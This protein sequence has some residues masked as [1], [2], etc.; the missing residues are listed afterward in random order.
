MRRLVAPPCPPGFSAWVTEN[1]DA[2]WEAF[3]NACR[4]PGGRAE[5][6]YQRLAGAQGNL[7]AYCEIRLQPPLGA[8][9]EHVH[10]K[11][12]KGPHNWGLDFHNLVA[13]CEGGQ[14]PRELPAR[15]G[16]PLRANLHCGAR[17]TDQV[18]D[19]LIFDPRA[20]PEAPV[21]ALEIQHD[22]VCL[23]PDSVALSPADRALAQSTL[24]RLGLNVPVLGRLRRASLDEAYALL[25]ADPRFM[26]DPQG[27]MAA[28]SATL[29]APDANGDL[30]PFWTTLRLGLET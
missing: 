6:L 17:K 11:S 13:G 22:R 9:V 21:W 7:C 14:R 10:P 27:A 4:G 12:D 20:L 15:A 16:T 29:L 24:D 2:T 3:K 28:L 25:E 1:P 30:A 18:L 8:E 19:G 26:D 23:H 5:E